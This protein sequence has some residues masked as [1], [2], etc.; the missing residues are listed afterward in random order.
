MKEIA[1]HVTDCNFLHE[2]VKTNFLETRRITYRKNTK[3]SK[4]K[5]TALFHIK[6]PS[7]R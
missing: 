4:H 6:P 2:I 1:T 5:C 3:A 7:L